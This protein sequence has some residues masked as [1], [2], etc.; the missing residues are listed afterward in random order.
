MPL[1]VLEK[2]LRDKNIRNIA[3]ILA[4]SFLASAFPAA[5]QTAASIELKSDDRYRGRSISGGEPVVKIAISFDSES[6]IYLGTSSRVTLTGEDRAG[7]Q[8][9]EIYA[10]YTKSLSDRSRVDVGMVGY[11]FTDRYSGNRADQFGEIY[12]G[13]HS[14][15]IAVY[16]HYTPNY[17]DQSVPV[18]YV[19]A[20]TAVSLGN[21]FTLS[22]RGG[23]LTQISDP[24]RLAAK[25]WRYDTSLALSRP[26]LGLDAQVA[27]IFA[28][29]N[30][31]Y[32]AGPWDGS[33]ALVFGIAKHF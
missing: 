28:G 7:L 19:S 27:L 15:N 18:L 6:G 14:R 30:D 5:A 23:V 31:V 16:L 32:F 2:L 3:A 24:P 22:A 11:V 29:P 12:I 20:S 17:F 33:S 26:V 9:A 21:D 1:R 10:G 13:L 4:S 8:G 25:S